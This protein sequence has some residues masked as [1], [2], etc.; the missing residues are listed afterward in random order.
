M[1]TKTITITEDAYASIKGLKSAHESFSDL[2]L[3]ISKERS[4]AEKYFGIL[5]SDA[6]ELQGRF[7]KMRVD[8]DK[9]MRKRENVLI[10]HLSSN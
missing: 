4:I 2:F 9:E 3:R 6:G 7:R 10:R 8:S 5:K 1:A